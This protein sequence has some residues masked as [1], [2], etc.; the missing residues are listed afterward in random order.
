MSGVAKL[1]KDSAGRA[2]KL[3]GEMIAACSREIPGDTRFVAMEGVRLKDDSGKKKEMERTTLTSGSGVSATGK[4]GER[5][6]RPGNG[7][8]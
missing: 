5:T 3:Y 7:A 4:E 8:G 2:L 1:G 6:R